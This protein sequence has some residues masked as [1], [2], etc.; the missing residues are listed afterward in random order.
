M[1]QWLLIPS[2]VACCGH[3]ISNEKVLIYIAHIKKVITKLYSFAQ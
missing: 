1:F 3:L 2:G